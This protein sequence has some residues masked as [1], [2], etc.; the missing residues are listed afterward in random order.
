[1][2]LEQV[3]KEIEQFALERDWT[4]F[5]TVRNLILAIQ[6]EVGELA[7]L[8]QWI[9]DSEISDGWLDANRLRLAE[10][11]ADVFI[12]LLRLAQVAGIEPESAALN[13][14]RINREKYPVEKA[15][16]TAKKYTDL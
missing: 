8:V 14:I 6:A 7:E 13:K 10:E 11:W 4:Q 12:Y 3:Q 1:M 16:G 2:G 15:K 9:P 5:H